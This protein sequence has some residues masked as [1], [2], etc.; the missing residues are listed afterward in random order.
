MTAEVALETVTFTVA[1][2]EENLKFVLPP[3]ETV[4]MLAP[5]ANWL[6]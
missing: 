3:Y 2:P 4:T 1:E 6:P 5:A